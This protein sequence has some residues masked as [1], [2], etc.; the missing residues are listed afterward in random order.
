M[1]IIPEMLDL[2]GGLANAPVLGLV[3]V[4]IILLIALTAFI[5]R[6]NQKNVESVGPEGL[7]WSQ[8]TR[9]ASALSI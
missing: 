4:A 8:V 7:L 2:L 6:N 9:G 1:V 5:S 3:L